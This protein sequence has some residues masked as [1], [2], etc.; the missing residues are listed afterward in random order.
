MSANTSSTETL[1]NCFLHLS[2]PFIGSLTVIYILMIPLFVFV[3]VVDYQRWRKQRSC[4]TSSHINVFTYNTV[5]LDLLC[6]LGTSLMF[7]SS[8]VED[9]DLWVAGSG[10]FII[11]STGHM[12][13]HLLTCI[14]RYLA[15]V[16]PISY[17]RLRGSA[18]VRIR[19]ITIGCVWLV[20]FVTMVITS[21]F[22]VPFLTI[23]FMLL[24]LTTVTF[25]FCSLS[26]LCVLIRPGPGKGG[27]NREGANQSKQ[28]AFHTMVIVTVTLTLRFITNLI[29]SVIQ[30]FSK[31]YGYIYC[32]VG[33]S[34][35]WFF[36]PSS[37]VLPLLFL[38][39][40]GKLLSL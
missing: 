16:H 6:V 18:G 38:Q 30:A 23:S 35:V 11:F 12:L 9:P 13:F 27:R 26:V 24:S 20:A 2:S 33:F 8:L 34:S 3:L 4:T 22:N 21:W 5:V 29:F 36:I 28:K 10:L 19:T 31:L 1:R 15:V 14:E 40:V 39:R 25:C 32:Y 37:L 7:F 17:L